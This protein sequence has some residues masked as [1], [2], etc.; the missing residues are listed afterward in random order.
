M[1][2]QYTITMVMYI[3]T[4]EHQHDHNKKTKPLITIVYLVFMSQLIKVLL[5]Q[6][7]LATDGLTALRMRNSMRIQR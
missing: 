5:G 4:H 3:H 7:V 1:Y 6:G 2:I